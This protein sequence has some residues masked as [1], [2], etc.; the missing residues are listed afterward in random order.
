MIQE[1]LRLAAVGMF[2][3]FAFLTLLVA[4]MRGSAAFF[5]ANAH[6]FPEEEPGD[7]VAGAAGDDEL[8]VVLAV[9]EALRRGHRV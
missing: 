1:G 9:S 2:T 8:A 6:R 7:T 3:V 4:M 5:E